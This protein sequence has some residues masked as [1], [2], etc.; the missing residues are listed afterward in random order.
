L[1]CQNQ[2]SVVPGATHLFEEHGALETVT[3]LTRDWFNDH[4]PPAVRARAER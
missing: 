3:D 4:M 1:R 2:L